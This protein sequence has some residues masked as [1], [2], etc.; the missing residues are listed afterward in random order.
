M[1]AKLAFAL[2]LTIT[3]SAPNADTTD[4]YILTAL[5]AAA[6]FQIPSGTPVQGQKLLIRIK[7]N[8]TGRALT[9]NAIYRAIGVT[10]PTTTVANKTHYIGAVYSTTDTKWDVLAVGAEA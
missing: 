7:D 8:G 1:S 5:A 3:T 9:Y 4:V 2:P 6:E 10:L